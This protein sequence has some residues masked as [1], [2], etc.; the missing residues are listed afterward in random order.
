MVV[1]RL[2]RRRAAHAHHVSCGEGACPRSV[3]RGS[4]RR[5]L[6]GSGRAPGVPGAAV[7]HR[8]DPVSARAPTA[9]C[10]GARALTTPVSL[11]SSV[12]DAATPV[13]QPPV[14]G[15]D[16]SLAATPVCHCRALLRG[17]PGPGSASP[18]C[19]C[20]VAGG[21]ALAVPHRPT[22]GDRTPGS[23]AGQPAVRAHVS[24]PPPPLPRVAR[25]RKQ[26]LLPESRMAWY[27][28]CAS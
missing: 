28:Q 9:P 4:R 22:G 24:Q 16:R 25:K 23:E 5:V 19:R 11:P 2:V 1:A 17:G 15:R 21:A 3:V 12:A 18:A 13:C 20:C 26:A 6:R 10:V 7:P 8:S 27:A 14:N